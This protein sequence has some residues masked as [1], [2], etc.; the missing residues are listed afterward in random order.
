M[1]LCDHHLSTA[2]AI[3]PAMKRLIPAD[4]ALGALLDVYA[5]QELSSLDA[6]VG[7][8]EAA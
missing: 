1:P 6:T 3:E 4:D 5:V 8:A 2:V 7:C